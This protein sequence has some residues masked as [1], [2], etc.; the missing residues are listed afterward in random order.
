MERYLSAVNAPPPPPP[1]AQVRAD[2]T[3]EF[4]I[5]ER[6]YLRQYFSMY[7]K[8][9]A[10]LRPRVDAAAT[11]KWKDTRLD[12][13]NVKHIKKILDIPLNRW[14][15]VSGTVFADAQHKLDIL[16][17]VENGEDDIVASV[18]ASYVTEGEHAKYAIEDESGRAIL[19]NGDLLEKSG[20]VTGC[21]VAVLGIELEAG[22]FKISE[23]V[24]PT[25]APQK[26]LGKFPGYVAFV[27]GLQFGMD[28]SMPAALLQQWLCGELGGAED[29]ELALQI[30]HLV[31]AGDSVEELAE[32]PQTTTFGSK[33]VLRF[34][35]ELLVA[36]GTWL[37]AVAASMPVSVMPGALDPLE[38]ALPQ[39]P[40]HRSLLGPASAFASVKTVSNPAW[41]EFD[42]VRFLGTSGQNISDVLK[43]RN[44]PQTS[45]QAMENTLR[46]LCI[47]PTAPD[48]LF[49]YPFEENDPFTLTETPHVYFAGNQRTAGLSVGLDGKVT[50]VSVPLF[51]ETGQ[52]VLLNGET[53]EMR[54]VTFGDQ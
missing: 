52:I 51:S 18:P 44:P 1:R 23:V 46:W 6:K 3:S 4:R 35:N 15:W 54:T 45:L 40:L 33:N 34:E 19:D 5:S 39:Q 43:Y 48:T 17:D 21:V 26:P 2:A 20:L 24:C 42:G 37:L 53:M 29:Q 38:L 9:L 47:V 36:F 49:C 27:S 32:A 13:S 41:L 16:K 30:A 10:E 8:R 28:A 7:Q 22:V 25:P 50:C 11:E 14:C 12:G 31:I